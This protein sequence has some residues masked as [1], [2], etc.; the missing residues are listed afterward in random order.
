LPQILEKNRIG[1]DRS[2][3]FVEKG[4][5]VM[6]KVNTN[7]QARFIGAVQR[8]VIFKS[9]LLEINNSKTPIEQGR[10]SNEK[11]LEESNTK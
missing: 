1:K 8:I 11:E 2:L 9:L 6:K 4:E 3:R 5:P 10:N 7:L